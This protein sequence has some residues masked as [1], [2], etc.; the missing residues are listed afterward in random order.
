MGLL[1]HVSESKLEELR[2]DVERNLDRYLGSGFADLAREPGWAIDL[3]Q[4]VDLDGLGELDGS[5]NRADSD[6]KNTKVVDRVLG[7]LSASLA[8]EERIWVRL[9]HVEGFEYSRDRWL[10]GEND[11]TSQMAAVEAHFFA[12]TQTRVRDDHSL[13]RLWWNAYIVKRC[14]PGDFSRGLELLLTTADVRSNIVERIWLTGRRRLAAGVFRAMEQ[15]HRVLASE[16]SFREFMKALNFLGGGIVFEA[17]T[18]GEIDDF[19]GRC[20]DRAQTELRS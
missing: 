10:K 9:S 18:D 14:Y 17:M 15:D 7:T 3:N 13:S 2:S 12:K 8:N 6:L 20:A 1:T 19:L 5:S 16:R 11:K 4:S